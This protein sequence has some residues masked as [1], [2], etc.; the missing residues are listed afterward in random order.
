MV[1]GRS[2][3]AKKYWIVTGCESSARLK[4]FPT[5]VAEDLAVLVLAPWSEYVSRTLR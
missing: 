5:E 1:N 3:S 2:V 4:S